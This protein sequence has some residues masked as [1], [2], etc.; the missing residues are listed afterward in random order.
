MSISE[1]LFMALNFVVPIQ[2]TTGDEILTNL[3]KGLTFQCPVMHDKL[4]SLQT[5]LHGHC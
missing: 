5:F 1:F 3:D 4:P 2:Y